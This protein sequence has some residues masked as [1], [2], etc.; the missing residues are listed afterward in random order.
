M[1]LVTIQDASRWATDY[2][3]K[4]VSPTNISYL[5]QYGKVK[6][7]GENGSTLV[8]LN[9]LKKYYASWRGQR[10][11]DWK[12]KLGDDLNWALSF[13]HLREKDT[14]KHVHRLHPYKGKFIPQLVQYFIDDHTDDFKT[15]AY[16]KKGDIVLD[17]FSGSGTTL[18]QASEMGMHAIGIDVSHFN[19][20]IS[21]VKLHTYDFSSLKR[22]I[23]RI[24]NAIVSYEH[25]NKIVA[26]E[27]ELMSE[28]Y[29]FNNEYFPSPS[30]R[31]QIQQ[32]KI[33]E[34]KYAEEKEKEFLKTYNRLVKKYGVELKQA[35]ADSFL[36]KWYCQ[37]VRKEI[38]FAFGLIKEIKDA[39][40]KKALAVILSRTIRS[41]RATT[42]SD[43]ATLKEPQLTTYYCWKHKKICKPLYSIKYWFDRYA[44]D[45]LERL[46][47][48]DRL[49]APSHFTVL[50]ADS[51]TVNI[52]S[53][54]KK[55]NK[56]LHE[57]LEKQKIR[58]IF[59][60]PPYVGQIDYH[61][62]HAYAYDLFGFERKDDLEIG[63][64]YKGQGLEARRSYVEGIANVLN[65]CKKYLQ[66]DYDVFLV[67]NDKFNL[68]P[69]IAEKSGMKIVNQFKRPVLN[70]TERDRN[71]YS[72]IIFHFKST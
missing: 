34:S 53:E 39:R 16:F 3:D 30:F 45:T 9:D 23:D 44:S 68:Y 24:R 56:A 32:R 8:D 33:D 49:R 69:E 65:N 10:E 71:P 59:T 48:F 19:C 1:S 43:L 64:L 18:V 62:Q 11:V 50:P 14:T 13:D 2:L 70:R 7:H 27:N 67:A 52:V 12:K 26:F 42:H 35:K 4:E 60:S 28:L 55:R 61:E 5:V 57:I 47:E 20:M 38:D 25:D 54:T 31:Y 40:N 63:P 37:N 72:E 15:D 22:E 41:C 21:D 29:K 36:D 66:N 17:P 51:R 46:Q 58:G 6:K